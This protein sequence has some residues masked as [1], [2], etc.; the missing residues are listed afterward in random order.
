MYSENNPN[1]PYLESEGIY[2]ALTRVRKNL[3]LVVVQNPSVFQEIQ[4]IMTRYLDRNKE[5]QEE[6]SN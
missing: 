2:Q 6:E 3:H 1:Y 5:K 4:G